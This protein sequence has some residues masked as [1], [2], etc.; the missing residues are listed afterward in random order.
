MSDHP[1]LHR[2]ETIA[3]C[4]ACDGASLHRSH[5][6]SFL[7]RYRK[8]ITMKRPF[9][10][11]LCGWRGWIDETRLRYPAVTGTPLHFPIKDDDAVPEIDL[12]SS[13]ET[14]PPP[15]GKHA[16]ATAQ[17]GTDSGAGPMAPV[18]ERAAPIARAQP[19]NTGD[20]AE[21]ASMELN[22]TE[23]FEG[24]EERRRETALRRD[25]PEGTLHHTAYR[26]PKCGE[27]SLFRSHHRNLLESIKRKFTGRRLYRCH[28]CG[29]RG[30][31]VRQI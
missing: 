4:P 3:I 11:H 20:G 2:S 23:L 15:G 14:L 22:S 9:R 25:V 7:D 5:S 30:W 12:D 29:W 1:W 16:S 27:T 8:S 6:L 31:L 19:G 28:K 18:A 24:A 17:D 13:D 10:C 21:D 26:C